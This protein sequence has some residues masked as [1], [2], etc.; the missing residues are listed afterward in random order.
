MQG[1]ATESNNMA[2]AKALGEEANKLVRQNE[3]VW[4]KYLSTFLTPEEAVLTKTK[5]EQ[6]VQYV[7]SMNRTLQLASAGE[8][9]AAAQ[10]LSTDTVPKFNLIRKI[11]QLAEANVPGEPGGGCSDE[12]TQ[13]KRFTR[14]K[15]RL[16]R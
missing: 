10:N 4:A 14:R 7:S 12:Q 1:N 2:T 5:G 8:F 15:R 6:R 9:E 3:G 16:K 11:L 13:R